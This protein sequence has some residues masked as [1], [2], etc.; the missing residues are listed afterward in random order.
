M[1]RKE[2]MTKKKHQRQRVFLAT[3]I[4]VCVMA[5]TFA[6]YSLTNN[7]AKTPTTKSKT[8]ETTQIKKETQ[9]TSTITIMASGDMLYHDGVYGSAFDGEKYDFSNDYEQ[10]TPLVSSA[11][12]ALG[13]FEGTINPNRE[14]AGY[15]IFNA[16]EEVVESIKN[17]GY[18]AIDLAHNHILDTGIEGLVYT[19]DAFK[20]AGMDPFGVK[21]TDKDEILVKKVNGIKVA[22]L[23]YSYG[24]NGIEATLSKEDYDYYLKDLTMEKVEA[25]IKQAEKIADLTVVMPQS[26]VE[27]NLEPTEEQQTTYRQMV[28]WG[29]DIVF[30]GHPHVVEPTETITKDGEKKFIIYSMGNLLSNQRYETLENYWTERGV[31][32]AVDVQKTGDKT[33]LT[34]VEAHPTW[35]SREPI[36]R[37]FSGYQ[38]YD[39]QVFLAEDY[40]PGGK[41]ADQMSTEK[42]QRIEQGYHEVMDLLNIQF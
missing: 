4:T 36:N 17:A 24:F 1:N 19:Y 31:I 3:G 21:T 27:Y 15:P 22:I 34:K 42:Q 37:T 14:L 13:D 41:Y 30:G 40:L 9:K 10:I 11:D 18:D 28:D 26:G 38:A 16:P 29:A 32:M 12:L 23:G 25:E 33:V 35:V 2:R 5:G 20:K 6:V 39:Y 8:T 7:D